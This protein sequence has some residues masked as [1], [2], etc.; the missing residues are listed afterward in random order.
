MGV[1]V[2]YLKFIEKVSK[3]VPQ[4]LDDKTFLNTTI[5]KAKQYYNE[6]LKMNEILERNKNLQSQ[7][8]NQMQIMQSQ[9]K[10]ED[11]NRKFKKNK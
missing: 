3:S 9:I 2:Q 8:N 1:N 10:L 5:T 7:Y 6:Q 11:Q 4:D